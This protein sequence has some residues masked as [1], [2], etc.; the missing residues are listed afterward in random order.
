MKEKRERKKKRKSKR[1]I[2]T[3][4]LLPTSIFHENKENTYGELPSRLSL[5]A[6]I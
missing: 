5:G 4:K 6:F 3:F 1:E 2:N